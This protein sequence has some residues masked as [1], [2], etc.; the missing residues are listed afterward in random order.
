MA[1]VPQNKRPSCLLALP[2]VDISYVKAMT[3]ILA[4]NFGKLG[5]HSTHVTR[6]TELAM[7]AL[8]IGATHII[9]TS[10]TTLK[11]V[12]PALQGS[13]KDNYGTV[14]EF[15]GIRGEKL[16][17]IFV[18]TFLT[19]YTQNYG[20]FLLE[21]YCNK[22]A[23]GGIL[24]KDKFNWLYLTP[25]ILDQVAE[26]SKDSFLCGVDI[27]TDKYNLRITSCSYTFCFDRDGLVVTQTYVVPCNPE[28]YPF[29]ID[30]IRVLNQTDVPKVM[31]NG[32][33][34][35]AYFVRFNAPIHNW[36]YDTHN[37]MHSLFSELP[38]DLGFI[39]A[40]FLDNFRFWKDEAGQN[41]YEYNAKDT[42][43][44]VWV[45]MAMLKYIEDYHCEYALANYKIEFPIVFP[46]LSCGLDGFYV[47]EER[48]LE[49]RKTAV[50]IY[51]SA[52][53]RLQNLV[54]EPDFNPGS[55][56]Q[57]TQLLKAL[58][59][60]DVAGTDE[61]KLAKL[62][63]KDP[64]IKIIV[65]LILEY[66][67]EKKAVSTYFDM[68]LLHQRLLY[69][70]D[71]AGTETGRMA[72][73]GSAFWCGTQ[74]Q[75]IP[76]YARAMIKADDGWILGAVDKCQSE[77]YCTGYISQDLTLIDVVNN[78]PDFHCQ[79][80]SMFFGIPFE[81]LFDTATGKKLNKAIRDIA[82]KVNH[83][84]NY[85]MGADVLIDTMGAKEIIKARILLGLPMTYSLRDVATYLLA[86]FDKTYTRIRS[87]WYQEIINEVVKTGKLY[88]PS[89]G[90]TRRTFLRPLKN[91][92]DLN[93][94]VAHKPQ[95]L[96]VHLV[97]KAFLKVW[98]ELQIGKYYGKFRLK[99]QVHDELI[100]Q[101]DPSIIDSCCEEVADIMVIPTEVNGR[102]M[103][104]PSSTA[105]GIYWNEAKD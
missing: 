80:A 67:G 9:T 95:S 102:L 17:M 104:I 91:K 20:S 59:C 82:K 24:K 18:P 87:D 49:L 105:K 70:C 44:T 48:R 73:T 14:V 46:G 26:Q 79:N 34:D 21:H 63:D 45:F 101:T 94:A 69:S 72:S 66:R 90:W 10:F 41:L 22:L 83:G 13:A 61:K 89:V 2:T 71:P 35:A 29:C 4:K 85:N 68:S 43:N 16:R 74:I 42:H 50:D 58:G 54:S 6:K 51:E 28:N 86:K 39:S 99:A 76:Q 62:A 23:R 31:Q 30:A 64:L 5:Y 55:P 15:E 97:N 3:G 27:E 57:V 93:A 47:D 53:S 1:I 78:S 81:K 33:Y 36:L 56:Q 60:K 77:S 32:K 12:N 75:N 19:I 84:A 11:I 8:R 100:F 65:D 38:K 40:F 25:S 7:Q 52:L 98:R 92:P 88:L 96:S 37:M 103:T